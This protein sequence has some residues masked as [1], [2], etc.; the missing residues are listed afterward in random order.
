MSSAREASP[1]AIL[2]AGLALAIPEA[3][4][5]RPEPPPPRAA[6]TAASPG[7]SPVPASA[8][9]S[10]QGTHDI[11]NCNGI[12]AWAWDKNRPDDPLELDVYDGDVRLATVPAEDFRQDLLT[13]GVGNGRHGAHLP[14]PP[15][16]KDG[17]TH[18]IWVKYAGTS[19]PL[20]NGPKELTCPLAP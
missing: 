8:P 4:C 9:A 16:L 11:V 12:M 7:Q 6:V 18:A 20:G 19:T 10:Y 2:L 13:A 15:R 1:L 17:R 5:T 3:S 14:T